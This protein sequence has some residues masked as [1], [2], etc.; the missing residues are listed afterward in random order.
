MTE[1]SSTSRIRINSDVLFQELQ[2][3]AVLLDLNEGVYF[4]LDKVGTRMWRLLELHG[5]IPGVVEGITREFDVDESRC[6]EDALALVKLLQEQGLV[7]VE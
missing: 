2:G 5:S 1:L 4:G 7:V 3:E 6:A